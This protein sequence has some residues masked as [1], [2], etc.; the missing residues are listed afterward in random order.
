MTSRERMIKVLNHEEVDRFPRHFWTLPSVEMF[1]MDELKEFKAN[2]EMDIANPIVYFG[3]S[4]Y[5]KGIPCRKGS[6]TDEFGS[7]WEVGEDGVIGEVKN[8]IFEDWSVLD[9]YQ[10][11]WEIIDQMDLLH[12]NESCKRSDK[13]IVAGTHIRPFERMQF[14]RGTENLFMDLATG[15][16]EVEKLGKMLHEFNL[17]ELEKLVNTDVDGVSFM[18]DW[19]SQ[20]SLLISPV[21]WRQVFK[22]MYKD[23]CDMAHSRGKYVFFHSDGN[24]E[25]IYPELIEIGINAINSQLFCMDIERLVEKNGDKITFWGEIDRQNIVPFGT[26]TD[27]ENAVGRV[28]SAVMTKNKKR[29]GAIAQCEWNACDPYENIC[30]VFDNWDKY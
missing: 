3:A 2:Y 28:A 22:P 25:S 5:S 13:F 6:Y 29:T 16:P 20:L 8:P 1:K 4:K 9:S 17:K 10:M 19:G 12:A 11:P 15:E 27:V 21:L 23:Y 7:V 18:D 30:A 24:I 26:T 14:M